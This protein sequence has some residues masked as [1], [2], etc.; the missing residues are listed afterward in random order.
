[1]RK[2]CRF[3]WF[4][5]VRAHWF[6]FVSVVFVVLF[7]LVFFS[8]V[9]ERKPGLNL[10]IQWPQVAYTSPCLL[11]T[12]C[13]QNCLAESCLLHADGHC[14]SSRRVVFHVK[15]I[16]ST[17]KHHHMSFPP[18]L[19]VFCRLYSL[20][21][22][23]DKF[24]S[25]LISVRAC[26]CVC[27]CVHNVIFQGGGGW[28][29]GETQRLCS[30]SSILAK[31]NSHICCFVHGLSILIVNSG[32]DLLIFTSLATEILLSEQMSDYFPPFS[33]LISKCHSILVSC[34]QELIMPQSL[35][36]WGKELLKSSMEKMERNNLGLL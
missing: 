1:M 36:L 22:P 35:I 6:Y 31:K 3:V 4:S 14:K 5:E 21:L 27:A 17:A 13:Y 12:E 24:A 9:K 2:T 16:S 33:L 11:A 8:T 20:S 30:R 32:F 19:P 29:G 15:T 25:L 26:V 18:L 10:I 23:L 28:G 34:Q 7:W